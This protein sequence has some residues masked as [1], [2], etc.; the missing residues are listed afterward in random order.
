[1]CCPTYQWGYYEL[2]F[3]AIGARVHF[4]PID[5]VSKPKLRIKNTLV[6]RGNVQ[7]SCVKELYIISLGS[8]IM[9]FLSPIVTF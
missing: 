4:S 9:A 6:S 8:P 1:M 2:E 5:E 7:N 3:L